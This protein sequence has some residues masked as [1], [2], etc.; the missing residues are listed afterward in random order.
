[1]HRRYT[2]P[3][4][5]FKLR[6]TTLEEIIKI[7][8]K[9][10]PKKAA[11]IYKIKP[12]ILKDLTPF[13]E[14]TL[15]KLFNKSIDEHEYPD[16]LK[17]TK[18]IEIYK[19]KLRTLPVNYRPLSLL[20]I[21]AKILDTIINNQLMDHLTSNNIISPTQY[22][23]RPNSSTTLALQTIINQLHKQIKNRKP[24]LAI[25][26]DLSK[27]YDTISHA[28][29]IHKLQHE[30]N[31]ST[32]TTAFFASY[33]RNRQQS[34]HTQ[35]AQSD[36]QTITH[37]I[38]QGSTLS[39]TFFLLYINNII[40]TVPESKVYTYAD[41]TTLIITTNSIGELQK[42]AQ[43]ELNNLINYFRTNKYK[44]T[45]T[46]IIKKL[47]PLMHSFKYANKFLS[48]NIMKNQYFM[49]AYPHLIGSITIWGTDNPTKTYIQPLIR[50]Q[51]RLVRLIKNLP[52]RTHTK[53]LMK[54]LNLLNL[55]NLY[56]MR[57]CME[58]Q[59]FIHPQDNTINR[60]EHNHHYTQTAEIHSHA[61]RYSNKQH[62]YISHD[63]D[64]LTKQYTRIWN[65]LPPQLRAIKQKETFKKEIQRYLMKQ[66]NES[67]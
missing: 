18:V 5:S 38:P 59:S 64:H 51:K 37:G 44:K 67:E 23:F 58:V 39:T 27:A 17:F 33:F 15:F 29:L 35:H 30:F 1:M 52:S 19:A 60:P 2:N 7:M 28:K 32:E 11:D 66:Q 49:H 8:E 61:T 54:E 20:P 63:T 36:T 56:I 47:Q 22:A 55:I 50:T 34:T 13:I 21:I 10:D 43:S 42:L 3:L 9:I 45:I 53:P 62:Q 12:A 31:F 25:Y 4:S 16:S 24:T 26:V 40:Q 46:L 6:H 65:K 41:D 48:S 57:V 14:P